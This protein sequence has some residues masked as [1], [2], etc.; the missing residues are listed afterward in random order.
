MWGGR[1]LNTVLGKSLPASGSFGESWEIFDFPAGVVEGESGPV[2]AV[3]RDGPFSGWTLRRLMDQHSRDL[4]GTRRGGQFPLLIKYLDARED[5]SVQVHPSPEFAQNHPD[6][7]LKTEAWYVIEAEPGSR[8]LR[9]LRQHVTREL[10]ERALLDGSVESL[11]QSFPGRRGDCHFLPSGTVHALGGGILVA[12]V[13]TPSDTTFR[14]FDFNRVDPSTGSQRKLHV[15]EALQ[16]IRFSGSSQ[17]PPPPM[18][19]S[20]EQ[21]EDP[22]ASSGGRRLVEC[23]Y[24]IMDER[25]AGDSTVPQPLAAV[26]G[27]VM[28]VRGLAQLS[29]EGSS[30]MEL[31]TGDTVLIPACLQKCQIIAGPGAVWLEIH[32]MG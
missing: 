1:K 13:Q 30:S 17:A 5:L 20:K 10:F 26:P 7:H 15:A 22:K 23:P 11:I 12:E 18:V 21:P 27:I 8:I 6:S 16:C 25:T 3:V 32:G 9:G 19:A 2:S 4:L 29:Y 28:L 31:R 14:V 24:F